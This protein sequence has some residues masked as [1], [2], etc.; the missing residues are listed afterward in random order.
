MPSLDTSSRDRSIIEHILGYC[1]DINTTHT[2]F[3]VCRER[4]LSSRTY[5][6]AIG[7]CILQIGELIKHLSPEFTQ[8]HP[9][10][11]WRAAARARDTYAHHYGRI[12]FDIAWDTSTTVVKM[13]DVF[14]N[15][16]LSDNAAQQNP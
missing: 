9:Q 8:S 12:D 11:D 4:F 7:M 15:N 6:N 16:Y 3:E 14:C 2:E 10:I 1:N 5:Q 13:L